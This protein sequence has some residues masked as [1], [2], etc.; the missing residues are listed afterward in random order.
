MTWALKDR[1]D[2]NRY[3]ET[4]D[5]IHYKKMRVSKGMETGRSKAFSALRYPLILSK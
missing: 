2:L 1:N 4:T 5:G 3:V